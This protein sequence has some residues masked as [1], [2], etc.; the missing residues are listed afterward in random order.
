MT[1][2]VRYDVSRLTDDDLYL[3]NEGNHFRL[4]EKLGAHLMTVD[5]VEGTYFAV[6]APDAEQVFVMGD[7]N[8][9]DKASH[10]L[11]S[12]GRSGIW[13]GFIPGVGQGTLYKYHI[14][15][16]YNQYQVDKADA[17]GFYFEKPPHTASIVWDLDYTWGD[18]EWMAARH[19]HNALDSPLAIYEVPGGGCRRKTTASSP[20]G[21]WPRFWPTMWNGWASPTWSFCR[22]PSIPFT[23]PGDTRPSVILLP[24]AATAPPR[25]SCS[26]WTTCTSGASG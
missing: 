17:F 4:Y 7:F 20:T 22:S 21:S 19:R 26:W 16:R 5:G 11:G 24:P 3:F 1:E 2:K 18:E 12:R 10:P 13:E 15:S 8:G 9:W 25:I 14:R 23:A 6:W